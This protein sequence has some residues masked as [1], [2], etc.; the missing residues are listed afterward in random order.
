MQRDPSKSKSR[1]YWEIQAKLEFKREF[2]MSHREMRAYWGEPHSPL[3]GPMRL[4]S[5]WLNFRKSALRKRDK[6]PLPTPE[7]TGACPTPVQRLTCLL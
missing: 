2:F 5:K 7:V 4:F 6:G 1:L 3:Y